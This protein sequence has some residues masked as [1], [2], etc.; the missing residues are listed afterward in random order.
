MR[1]ELSDYQWTIKPMALNKPRG[2]WRVNDRR[3][4]KASFGSYVEVRHGA[5]C[6]RTVSHTRLTTI[7]SC[8]GDRLAS[9]TRSW[10]P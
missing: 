7:A 3:V 4:L 8:A 5:T 9:G 6:Q 2:V 1:C 10:M